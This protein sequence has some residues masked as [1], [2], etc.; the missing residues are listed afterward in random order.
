MGLKWEFP[1]GKI[2]VGETEEESIIREIQEELNIEIDI[3]RKLKSQKTE[4]EN[5][6]IELIPF[7]CSIRKGQII[8]RE[9]KN[10]LWLKKEELFKLDWAEP[11]LPI[12]EVILEKLE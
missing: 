10:I 2:E 5:V 12:V 9:H 11:D 1:G 4:L 3:I 6:I 7:I 8:N